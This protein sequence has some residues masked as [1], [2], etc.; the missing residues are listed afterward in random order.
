MKT[1]RY[2]THISFSSVFRALKNPEIRVSTQE[3]PQKRVRRTRLRPVDAYILLTTARYDS[4]AWHVESFAGII[5]RICQ[6][7]VRPQN[8]PRTLAA[9]KHVP[10]CGAS[11]HNV[12][13]CNI[14]IIL[15]LRAILIHRPRQRPVELRI[16]AV[17]SL[18]T[19]NEIISQHRTD[20][21]CSF[22]V[23]LFLSFA[24]RNWTNFVISF[25][26]TFR[27]NKSRCGSSND[28]VICKKK[29]IEHI[30]FLCLEQ[31][32]TK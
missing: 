12:S 23:I 16:R 8:S 26:I 25:F 11:V 21:F 20:L 7:K 30:R 10:L 28:K 32:Y 14:C 13:T 22:P 29:V 19:C 2:R 4:P 15:S 1:A 3:S 17:D 18:K 24:C 9:K 27:E 6:A 31:L 5:C